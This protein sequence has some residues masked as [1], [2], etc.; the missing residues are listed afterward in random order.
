[1]SESPFQQMPV[2]WPEF[3]NSDQGAGSDIVTALPA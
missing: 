2:C 3:I 1:L